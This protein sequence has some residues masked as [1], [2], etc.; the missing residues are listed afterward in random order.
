MQEEYDIELHQYF[1]ARTP[2]QLCSALRI[3]NMDKVENADECGECAEL[4][5]TSFGVCALGD[6][7]HKRKTVLPDH[8]LRNKLTPDQ[9]EVM[10][11]E[12]DIENFQKRVENSHAPEFPF[13]DHQPV[14][15]PLDK[16]DTP[17][18][19]TGSLDDQDII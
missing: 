5:C 3:C 17:K 10:M 15:K 4:G 14:F 19:Q 1:E 8:P 11:T 12:E 13:I 16:K 6:G 7:R 18:E 9:Y 2:L